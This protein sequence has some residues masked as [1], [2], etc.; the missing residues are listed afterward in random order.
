MFDTSLV[1]QTVL[2]A[3]LDSL[4]PALAPILPHLAEDAW[5]AM[6]WPTP[7]KS[8]FQARLTLLAIKNQ[9]SLMKDDLRHFQCSYT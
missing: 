2:A 1:S 9:E 8:V 7:T 3:A 4:L 6:P 5:L